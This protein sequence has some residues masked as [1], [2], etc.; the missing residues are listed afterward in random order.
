MNIVS[1]A[2]LW[3][4]WKL[5]NDMFSG[6]YLV[7]N[8]AGDTKVWKDAQKMVGDVQAGSQGEIGGGDP[9]VNKQGQCDATDQVETRYIRVGSIQCSAFGHLQR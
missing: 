8:E 4:I 5:R 7:G 6:N 1:P 9:T 3:T 2:V